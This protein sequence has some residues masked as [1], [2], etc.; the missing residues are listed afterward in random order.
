M[1]LAEEHV[2]AHE[3]EMVLQTDQEYFH[4]HCQTN[5]YF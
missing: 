4:F 3:Q 1:F 5:L 2:F